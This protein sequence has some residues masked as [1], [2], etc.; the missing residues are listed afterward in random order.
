MV[1]LY[2][3]LARDGALRAEVRA[4]C[5]GPIVDYSGASW[6]E[7]FTLEAV[8]RECAALSSAIGGKGSSVC[9]E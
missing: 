6:A 1:D 7:W 3:L 9:A 5:A 8:A 4:I 2:R